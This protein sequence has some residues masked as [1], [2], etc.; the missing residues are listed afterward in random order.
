M[1]TIIKLFFFLCLTSHLRAQTQI[2]GKTKPGDSLVLVIHGPFYYPGVPERGASHSLTT[3]ADQRGQFHFKLPAV[4]SPFHYS[5]FLTNQRNSKNGLLAGAGTV[6]DYLIEPG[7]SLYLS[8][9]QAIPSASGRGRELFNAQYQ[10]NLPAPVDSYG[11]PPPDL[12]NYLR[13]DPAK[14]L[15]QKDAVLTEQLDLLKGWQNQL[16]P[17]AYRIVRADLIGANR[18]KLYLSI[19]STKPFIAEGVRLPPALE[20]IYQELTQRP[21]LVD[22]GDPAALSP[23]YTDYLYK[24]L[25]VEVKH[26]QIG[27]PA[28]QNYFAMINSTY[29]GTLRDKLLVRW[30]IQMTSDNFLQGEY[31]SSALGVIQNPA[32]K[33]LAQQLNATHEKGSPVIDFDFKDAAGKSR[34]LSE[35]KGKVLFIDLWFSGCGGC[36]SVAEGLPNVEAVFKGRTDIA[37]VSISIDKQKALWLNSIQPH[38]KKQNYTHY[39]TATTHYWYT[40]GSGASNPFIKAYVPEGNYPAMLILDKNGLVFSASPSRPVDPAGQHKLVEEL[41]AAIAAP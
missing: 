28:D 8:F 29:T 11:N 23:K 5:L 9:D 15:R 3:T 16:S 14:W 27:Q 7:D 41:Q 25:V 22:P 12:T 10:S 40:G 18:G 34:H 31:L 26:S 4:N 38:P 32:L 30:L 1:K 21:V 13:L 24:K 17:L 36:I 37:F 19:G 2:G 20:A 35:L 6:Q 39:T 33:L